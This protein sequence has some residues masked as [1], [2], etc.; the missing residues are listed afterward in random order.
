M[1]AWDGGMGKVRQ[2]QDGAAQSRH[3]GNRRQAGSRRRRELDQEHAGLMRGYSCSSPSSQR[4]HLRMLHLMS[5]RADP[6]TQVYD[7]EAGVWEYMPCRMSKK[8][9]SFPLIPH[10]GKLYAVAGADQQGPPPL[11]PPSEIDPSTGQPHEPGY[12]ARIYSTAPPLSVQIPGWVG[13][14]AKPP[15]E[16]CAEDDRILYHDITEPYVGGSV[17]VFDPVKGQW[18]L[19]PNGLVHPR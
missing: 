19:L 17:D 10:G 16:Y 8:R 12:Y 5:I 2:P 13:G 4:K 11:P 3:G 1:E 15:G 7:P 6:L 14:E 9:M 18:E